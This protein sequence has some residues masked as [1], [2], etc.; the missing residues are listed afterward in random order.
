MA[1]VNFD[2]QQQRLSFKFNGKGSF[3]HSMGNVNFYIQWQ[4]LILT[5]NGKG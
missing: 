2:N 3:S 1:K 5:I 4:R